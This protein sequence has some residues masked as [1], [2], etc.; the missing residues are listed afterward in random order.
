MVKNLPANAGDSGSIPGW[1]RSPW[2]GND[3]PLQYS[4]LENLLVR[5]AWWAAV[6]GVAKSWTRPSDET[7]TAVHIR[8]GSTWKRPARVCKPHFTGEAAG[9]LVQAIQQESVSLGR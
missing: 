9:H 2:E 4:C 8:L 6:S 3:N 1:G 5:E 7:A